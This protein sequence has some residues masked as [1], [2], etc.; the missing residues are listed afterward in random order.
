M[1]TLVTVRMFQNSKTT[2]S[3]LNV[4][5]DFIALK[6]EKYTNIILYMLEI[7]SILYFI[8]F[9]HLLSVTNYA[10]YNTDSTLRST[11]TQPHS[12]Y[13]VYPPRAVNY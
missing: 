3:P 6:I 4:N 9:S 13:L 5:N 12:F 7:L 8:I 1:V 11:R 2:D 10:R